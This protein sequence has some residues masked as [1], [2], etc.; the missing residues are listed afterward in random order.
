MTYLGKG[1]EDDDTESHQDSNLKRNDLVKAIV[2]QDDILKQSIKT[3]GYEDTSKYFVQSG[4]VQV[5]EGI[6]CKYFIIKRRGDWILS[7]EEFFTSSMLKVFMQL[8]RPPGGE[9]R[10]V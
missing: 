3:V 5:V 9:D 4:Q 7:W 6:E 10:E 8:F 2:K 1:S